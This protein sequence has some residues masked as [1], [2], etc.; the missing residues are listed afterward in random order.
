LASHS[1]KDGPVEIATAWNRIAAGVRKFQT[2]IFPQQRDL[3]ERL[4]QRQDPLALFI[5]CAD[6][7]VVPNLFTQTGPGEMFIE[8]N[9]GN[10]V[11]RYSNHVGGVTSG[12]EYANLVLKVP[13]IIVC[14]HT[15]CGVMK[16]LLHPDAA[17]GMPG[18]QEWMRHG[19]EARQVVLR[20]YAERPEEEK[21]RRLAEANVL[22]QI[23]N[24]KTHPSVAS[25]LE[26]GEVVIR[27]WVYDI[28]SGAV[29]QAD[30]NTGLFE[31]FFG[32]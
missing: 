6:S 2:E 32:A 8:R 16:A 17:A 24:L 19:N 14:G 4:R 12:V 15:D 27:G 23:A 22:E 26:T 31:D 28:G 10:M 29:R 25:R 7:R 13:L 11:P 30:L 5:T 1:V 21:V 18:V 9:P 3:F 20:D